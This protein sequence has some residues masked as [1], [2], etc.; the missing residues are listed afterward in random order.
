MLLLIV[1]F[2]LQ[3]GYDQVP[4]SG[5]PVP[6]GGYPMA[7][8]VGGY[9]VPGQAPGPGFAAAGESTLCTTK[10]QPLKS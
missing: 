1:C 3:G 8:G 7:G 4:G 6:G 9:G 10:V 2:M 5:Y